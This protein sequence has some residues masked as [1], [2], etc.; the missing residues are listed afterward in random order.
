MR[1]GRLLALAMAGVVVL[2]TVAHA[3]HSNYFLEVFT[4]MKQQN[5]SKEQVME[6]AELKT[7]FN[8]QKSLDHSKG[9]SCAAHDSHVP[10]FISAAA[11]VLDDQQYKA[12]TGKSKTEVQKLRYE[13]NQLRK[14]IAEL[15]QILSELEKK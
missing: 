3:C 4:K 1:T 15:K 10:T 7:E 9:L 2:A 13:V 14:E 5:L 8:R 12:A 11:G 6:L